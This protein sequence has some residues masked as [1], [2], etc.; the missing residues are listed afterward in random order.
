M[1]RHF[2]FA[3]LFELAAA[4]VPSRVALHDDRRSITYGELD[5]R[6]NRLAHVLLAAG[7]KPHDH[8]AVYAKNCVGGT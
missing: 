4:R 8:V 6:A 2:H 3:D 7:V 1:Q 5:A